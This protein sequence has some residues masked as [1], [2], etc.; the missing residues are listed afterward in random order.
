MT[1]TRSAVCRQAPATFL[2]HTRNREVWLRVPPPPRTRVGVGAWLR[3]A[4]AERAINA[5]TI[6]YALELAF[7]AVLEL[8]P[9][10]S[11]EVLHGA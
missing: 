3:G 7:A 8:D 2:R 5:P 11:H 6:R 9:R 1:A 10:S 4:S